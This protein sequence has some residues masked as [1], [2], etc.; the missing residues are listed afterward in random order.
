MLGAMDAAEDRV[1]VLHAM[2]NNAVAAIGAHWRE[3][4]D[5]AFDESKVMVRP[6]IL[7]SK[8]LS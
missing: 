1:A 7:T 6:P 3:R 4:L 2:S 5:R 8:L